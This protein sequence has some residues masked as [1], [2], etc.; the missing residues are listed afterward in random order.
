MVGTLSGLFKVSI[1]CTQEG[2]FTKGEITP[3]SSLP[4]SVSSP[5]RSRGTSEPH[6]EGLFHCILVS[7]TYSSS[8]EKSFGSLVGRLSCRHLPIRASL[9]ARTAPPTTLS[10]PLHRVQRRVPL[11]LG[12]RTTTWFIRA[13]ESCRGR[14]G[15]GGGRGERV[16][17]G[18]DNLR[19]R[20]RRN[21]DTPI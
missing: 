16:C 15:R 8:D 6:H 1:D 18:A 12:V 19:P 14:F 3:L 20:P 4:L 10:S 2:T 21:P 17:P 9:V 11:V 7:P 5:R 13:P